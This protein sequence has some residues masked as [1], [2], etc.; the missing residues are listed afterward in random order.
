MTLDPFMFEALNVCA[1]HNSPHQ[2]TE[3]HSSYVMLYED[4]FVQSGRFLIQEIHD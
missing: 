3:R 1:C 4:L 2:D